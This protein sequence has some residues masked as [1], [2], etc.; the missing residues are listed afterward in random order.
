MSVKSKSKIK[1]DVT[2]DEMNV[3]KERIEKI[4]SKILKSKDRKPL[5]ELCLGDS[6]EQ[7]KVWMKTAFEAARLAPSTANLQPWKFAV[8]DN[9]ITVLSTE[10]KE[11]HGASPYLDCGV[12]LMHLIIGAGTEDIEVTVKYLEPPRVAYIEPAD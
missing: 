8:E 2:M 6:L 11:R 1:T 4:L 9:G 5:Q 10:D 12:A 7:A 3:H